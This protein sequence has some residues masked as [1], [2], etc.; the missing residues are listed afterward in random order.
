MTEVKIADGIYFTDF[1]NQDP[2]KQQQCLENL[3]SNLEKVSKFITL[4]EAKKVEDPLQLSYIGFEA[5]K[6]LEWLNNSNAFMLED[7][8]LLKDP[9]VLQ[10]LDENA[11]VGRKYLEILDFVSQKLKPLGN[12]EL[13]VQDSKLQAERE[14]FEQQLEKFL[15]S[16]GKKTANEI[17]V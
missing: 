2:G 14:K 17:F 6:K 9:D 5:F 4:E 11:A 8:E 13:F 16:S 3:Q 7:A 12:K 10:A 1:R 15:A